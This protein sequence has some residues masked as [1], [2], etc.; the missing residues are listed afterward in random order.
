[1]IDR[2]S[3]TLRT[4]KV[5]REASRTQE[6]R[7]LVSCSGLE[8]F[9]QALPTLVRPQCTLDPWVAVD[10][11]A[12]VPIA[13]HAQ[14]RTDAVGLG[15]GDPP[16]AHLTVAAATRGGVLTADWRCGPCPDD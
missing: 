10:G 5:D 15:V 1:M 2:P 8:L 14:A 3:G 9:G 7:D 6:Q 4:S 12:P 16:G 13:S 11:S